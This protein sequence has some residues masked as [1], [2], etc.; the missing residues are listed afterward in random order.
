MQQ[1]YF[2]VINVYLS[3]KLLDS[4]IYVHTWLFAKIWTLAFGDGRI[5]EILL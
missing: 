3:S 1:V 2:G 4:K 5:L